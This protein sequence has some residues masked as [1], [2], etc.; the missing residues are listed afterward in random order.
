MSVCL[1]LHVSACGCG[2]CICMYVCVCVCVCGHRMKEISRYH[3]NSLPKMADNFYFW[4]LANNFNF[5]FG[6]WDMCLCVKHTYAE[7]NIWI[8]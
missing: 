1:F 2:I 5:V 4:C 6:M 3:V 7:R 8:L